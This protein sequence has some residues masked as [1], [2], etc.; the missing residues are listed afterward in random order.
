MIPAFAVGRSQEVLMLLRQAR[1]SGRLS[2]EFPIY[3][4][5][6]VNQICETYNEHRDFLHTTIRDTQGHLFFSKEI[7]IQVS[8]YDFRQPSTAKAFQQ[9]PPCC[10]IAS[11]GML[12]DGSRSA[13]YAENMITNACNLILFTGYLD[14]ESPGNKL[15]Q[16]NSNLGNFKL[17][18][19]MHNVAARIL[20]YH[21]SA[22]ASLEQITALVERVNPKRVVFVHGNADY[23]NPDNL[24]AKF[25]EWGKHTIQPTIANNQTPIYLG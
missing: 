13:R 21:L 6:M 15:L 8:P 11:S 5:G 10:V 16:A 4:D 9:S 24:F 25:Y 23:Q 7:G 22:H 1:E 17:N 18:G 12:I 20:P 2:K 3:T 19:K 14:E